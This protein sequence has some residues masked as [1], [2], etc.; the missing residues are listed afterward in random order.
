MIGTLASSQ[1]PAPVSAGFARRT[2]RFTPFGAGS[3]ADDFQHVFQGHRLEYSAIGGV[4]I[5]GRRSF[6]VA[7]WTM[8]GLVNRLSRIRQRGVAHSN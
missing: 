7:V 5:G 3:T 8:I 1:A 4:V 2:A 6:G